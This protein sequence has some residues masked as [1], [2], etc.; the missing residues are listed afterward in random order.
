MSSSTSHLQYVGQVC[1]TN[2]LKKGVFNA[3]GISEFVA[4][5]ILRGNSVVIGNPLHS[6]FLILP[7]LPGRRSLRFEK[8]LAEFTGD[9]LYK[10][11]RL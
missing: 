7:I 4:A 5:V 6:L 11:R 10:S 3:A 8:G 2:K 1:G 9:A